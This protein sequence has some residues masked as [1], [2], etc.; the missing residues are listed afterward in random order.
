MAEKKT[1]SS[2][3]ANKSVQGNQKNVNAQ[4]VKRKTPRTPQE[5]K[6]LIIIIVSVVL[7]VAILAGVAFAVWYAIFG[8]RFDYVG[9]NISKYI[10]ISKDDYYG[11]EINVTV[12]EVIGAEQKIGI[13]NRQQSFIPQI[14]FI[15][16]K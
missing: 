13:S 6:R 14:T 5:K 9:G 10:T 15:I 7:G 12:P 3:N 16:Q 2:K 1:K 8:K 4:A 11:Y